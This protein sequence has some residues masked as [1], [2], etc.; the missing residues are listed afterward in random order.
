M[1]RPF[2]LRALRLSAANRDLR[3]EVQSLRDD[4]DSLVGDGPE[5]LTGCPCAHCH[6]ERSVLA[7]NPLAHLVLTGTGR[8][9][10]WG[11]A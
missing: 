3:A 8:P 11:A 4:I 1:R 7:A 5:E 6:V 10:H 9:M 2:S